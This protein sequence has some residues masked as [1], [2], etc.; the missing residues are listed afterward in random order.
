MGHTCRITNLSAHAPITI[1]SRSHSPI[2]HALLLISIACAIFSTSHATIAGKELRQT[3]VYSSK[4]LAGNHST[5]K[6]LS[7]T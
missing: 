5:A 2:N 1:T 3:G 6:T 7:K 4:D